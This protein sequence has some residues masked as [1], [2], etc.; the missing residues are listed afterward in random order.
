M[1]RS[2]E[3]WKW[4]KRIGG[5]L[6]LQPGLY[7]QVINEYIQSELEKGHKEWFHDRSK[8]DRAESANILGTYIGRLLTQ[9]M[10]YIDHSETVVK[11]RIAFCNEIIRF[12]I[13]YLERESGHK[14]DADLLSNLK[15]QLIH[16]GAEMLLELIDAKQAANKAHVRP[17][18]PL[19]ISSLFTGDKR[20]PSMLVELKK[21]IATSDR[22]DFLVSFIKFSGLRLLLDDLKAFTMRGG[23]LRVITTSYMG[24]TDYKAVQELAKLPNTEVKISYDTNTTRLHAKA[25]LFWRNTGFSTLYIGS[26]NISESAMTSG[27]EWNVKLAQQD[28]PTIVKKVEVSFEQYWNNPEF[29]TFIPQLHE[30]KLRHALK[31]E[32]SWRNDDHSALS[33]YFDIQ[34]YYYQQEILDKLQAERDIHKRFRNL[35][36]AATGTGKTVISAFDYR[37]Y[38]QQN[39]GK[40]NR[41]LF[42]AHRKEILQQS[43]SCFR[44]ILRDLNF[45]DVMVAGHVPDQIDHLFV[46]IQS[47]NAKDLF[48]RTP[49]DFYDFIIVDE[50]HHAAAPSYQQLLTY[51]QPKI[52]LGLTATPERM[53][54]KSITDYFGGRIAAEMRLYEAIERKLLSP[55]HYFGVTDSVDLSG[56]KWRFGR[57]DE[58]ELERLFVIQEKV[59]KERARYIFEAV[60]RYC[61]DINDVIGIGFCVTKRHA[62]F[63][64]EQFNAFGV[65]SDYLTAESPDDVRD[66]V[67]QRLVRKEIHF[68][69]VVDLY[70]E[71]VDIPEVNT[72][73]FLRPTESLTV[74]LQQLGRGLR[75]YEG[76]E[77]LTVLDFVGQA[78]REYNFEQ[79]FQSLLSR[80]RRSVL[81]ELEL[82]FPSV[83]KGCSII[84]EKRAQ[85]IILAHIRSS[86]NNLKHIRRKVIDYFTHHREWRIGE[87]F[88]DYHVKPLDVYG[89]KTPTTVYGLGIQTNVVPADEPIDETREKLLATG[90]ERLSFSNSTR[91]L[92]FALQALQAIRESRGK[93]MVGLSPAE[94]K[95]L[96][97]LYYTFWDV[98]LAD[99]KDRSFDTLEEAL[100]WLVEHPLA[101]AELY[102]VLRY[103]YEKIDIV[104]R[105][106]PGLD[107]DIPIDLYCNYTTNQIMAALGRHQ[108]WKHRHFQEGVLYV[109]ERK[110]DVFFVTLVKSEKDYS[111]TTMYQDYAVNER[112]FHWQSQ[113]RTTVNSPTGRRYINQRHTKHPVLFFIREKKRNDYGVTMPYTCVGLADYKRHHGSAPISM[114]WTM[115]EPLPAFVLDVAVRG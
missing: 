13:D 16:P 55:F 28:A 25:Y 60:E 104:G 75:L 101:Y 6:M 54:G 96:L 33:F 37:R 9:V 24:A 49:P 47:L 61:T 81:K 23:Q 1:P 64:A 74:F 8:I 63:M 72:V 85:E 73:L 99:W 108:A 20:E 32:R 39:P 12:A 109:E 7:E 79:R 83:P 4:R 51:Y 71:G 34:P 88:E 40:P 77:A 91:F 36:V 46:S 43:L 98:G 80:T 95:M 92:E 100:Y 111:P 21:E 45:G 82:G 52:L 27:L 105:P 57:Y 29:V 94:Q 113:S 102:D 18:T 114:E 5:D 112:V 41:L 50:F 84:L 42:V 68:I 14:L 106:V 78:H 2:V 31:A 69:F 110:M 62:Q 11:D 67:K 58:N 48:A 53:D 86:I 15:G 87:F 17:E 97:M 90:L 107:E 56:V 30:Q 3:Y 10:Q 65:P 35:V 66:M 103:Q 59:A 22:I 76:K 44:S 26:S 93:P 115:R 70:N 89:R 38:C 19:S